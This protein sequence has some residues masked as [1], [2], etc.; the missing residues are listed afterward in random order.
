MA[1]LHRQISEL[2]AQLK[3]ARQDAAVQSSVSPAGNEP[4]VPVSYSSASG[5]VDTRHIDSRVDS[6]YI[7]L[8]VRDD[9]LSIGEVWDDPDRVGDV[10][11]FSRT[12]VGWPNFSM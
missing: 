11:N 5:K 3:V 6:E 10:S 4:A 8:R 1:A 12:G 9:E 2:Q 7:Y